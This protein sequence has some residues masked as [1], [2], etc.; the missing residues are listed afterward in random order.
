MPPKLWGRVPSVGERTDMVNM[1]GAFC[2]SQLL[3]NMAE[4]ILTGYLASALQMD[5]VSGH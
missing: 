4:A 1:K 3:E 2:F 5:M